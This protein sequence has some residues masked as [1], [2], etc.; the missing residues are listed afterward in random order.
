MKKINEQSRKH[1]F[2]IYKYLTKKECIRSMHVLASFGKFLDGFW[3]IFGTILESFCEA[4]ERFGGGFGRLFGG[5]LDV[6]RE[7]FWRFL[8]GTSCKNLTKQTFLLF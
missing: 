4:F 6:F 1:I 8:E 3:N 2:L 5:I 7:V